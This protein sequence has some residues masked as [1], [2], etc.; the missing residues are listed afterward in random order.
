MSTG[1][2]SRGIV[3]VAGGNGVDRLRE[4]LRWQ[5][6]HG[7]AAEWLEGG[8]LYEREPALRR[9]EDG[10]S[11]GLLNPDASSLLLGEF[12]RG[13]ARAAALRG[14][15][16]REHSMVIHVRV[17]GSRAVGVRTLEGDVDAGAVVIA[18]G[19]WSLLF[20]NDPECRFRRV[21]FVGR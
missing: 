3:H 11:G 12:A 15:K 2:T 8:A 21:R 4:T 6:E 16:I 5:Q 13:L 9:E 14:A 10:F 1:W 18:A 19:A 20:A 17:D 7:F